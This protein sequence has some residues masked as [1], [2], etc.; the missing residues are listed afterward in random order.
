MTTTTDID[1]QTW[2]SQDPY[3]GA[4]SHDRFKRSNWN[5]DSLREFFQSGEDHID[6]VFD[7][8]VS[9][10]DSNFDP[11]LAI[12]FGCG[13]G[14]LV[15]PL[16]RRCQMAIGVDVS[17]SMLDETCKNANRNGIKNCETVLSDD[18]LSHVRSDTDF[19][20]S[21]IVFQHIPTERG[22]FL[23][24]RLL[25]KLR[26]GGIAALH[27]TVH[28]NAT[29]LARL[30]NHVRYHSRFA[31]GVANVIQRKPFSTPLMRRFMY[32]PMDVLKVYQQAG[33]GSIAID[34]EEQG[35]C[36]TAIF[37]GKKAV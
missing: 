27:V 14:R 1:W 32:P 13:P 10:V 20:H 31:A 33:L 11:S 19:V 18:T 7:A 26:P 34:L 6:R 2:G 25:D 4:L 3:H 23:M 35:N 8:I 28:R 36:T 12:D 16:A 9:R 30:A 21:F 22:L 29:R 15:L 24:S 37:Y 5:D 17:Q